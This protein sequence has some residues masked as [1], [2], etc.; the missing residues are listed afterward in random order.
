MVS[1][2]YSMKKEKIRQKIKNQFLWDDFV[3]RNNIKKKKQAT[4]E[5]KHVT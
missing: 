5:L 1:K 4:V 2:V 3:V